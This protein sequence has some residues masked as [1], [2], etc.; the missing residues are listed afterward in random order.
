MP[1]ARL[2][3]P[4][5]IV[6]SIASFCFE[7]VW[8]TVFQK[9]WLAGIGRTEEWLMAHPGVSPPVQFA[10]ALA[11]SLVAAI[12]LSLLTQWTGP[13]TARRGVMLGVIVWVGFVATSWAKAYIFEVRTLEIYAI[14]TIYMLLD[15]MLIGAIAGAWKARPHPL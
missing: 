13:R 10:T 14:N 5:L 4:A 12:V 11:C 15:L 8:F 9:Q 1:P 3:W 2:H 6:A 7:A